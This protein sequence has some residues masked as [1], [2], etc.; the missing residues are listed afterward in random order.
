MIEFSSRGI[1]S[2]PIDSGAQHL[3]IG[4]AKATQNKQKL[5]NLKPM[6]HIFSDK[7]LNFIWDSY[8]GLMTK[9]W[10]ETLL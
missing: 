7:S 10:D 2:L 1:I 9:R 5:T 4:L 3:N 8:A 6:A